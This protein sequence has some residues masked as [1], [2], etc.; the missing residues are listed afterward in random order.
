[1]TV[2]S[3]WVSV[4]GQLIVQ[5]RLLADLTQEEIAER[6]GVTQPDI[7]AYE[8]GRRQPTLPTLYRILGA[9]GY[10][11]RIRLEPLDDHDATVAAWQATRPA[12]EVAE[13]ERQ[14]A[15]FTAR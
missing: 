14:Q 9:G 4:A 15:A 13:W 12:D 6:A 5:A 1:M 7:S 11:P 10:Q 8:N 3:E 2:E